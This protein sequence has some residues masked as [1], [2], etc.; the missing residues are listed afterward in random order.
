MF[1]GAAI[2]GVVALTLDWLAAMVYRYAR[3]KGL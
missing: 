3:P 2:V 1:A